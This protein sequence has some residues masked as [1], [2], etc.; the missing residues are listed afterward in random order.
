[1]N[2]PIK[3]FYDQACAM[4]RAEMH[5]LKA[6]DQHNHI[7]LIDMSN[8]HFSAEK[9][10]VKLS[11][12]QE[13]LHVLKPDGTWLI[14]VSAVKAS[15]AA[16]GAPIKIPTLNWKWLNGFWEHTY[17]WIARNRY[18]VSRFLRPLIEYWFAKR[19][20]QAMK[21][22]QNGVCALPSNALKK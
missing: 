21:Q 3:I 15:Y 12:L 4:C 2:T 7:E 8:E 20:Q 14:G 9:W 13:K 6:I 18:G 22:C 19:L 10:G 17:A 11:N 5:Y 16:V 1:M